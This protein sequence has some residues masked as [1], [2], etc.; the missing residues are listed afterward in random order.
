MQAK[1][2]EDRLETW[3]GLAE[4]HSVIPAA[5]ADWRHNLLK[6]AQ[7]VEVCRELTGSQSEIDIA[8]AGAL[9]QGGDPDSIETIRDLFLKV[10][11][12]MR[13]KKIV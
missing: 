1:E 3:I 10:L 6:S 4:Q 9:A 7:Q 13:E 5:E 8:T 11:R 12:E 2:L